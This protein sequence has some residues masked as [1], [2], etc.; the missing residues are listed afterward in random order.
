METE[1]SA[2]ET[3]PQRAAEPFVLVVDDDEDLAD[4]CQYWLDRGRYTVETA[5]GGAEALSQLGDHVDVVLL[6]RRMP[7]VSGDDVLEAIRERD[8]DCRV[9]MMTAV[10]PDTDIVEMPFD[11]YL[12]KPVSE[13]QVTETVEELLVRA[14]FEREVR[15]YFALESTHEALENRAAEE[16]RDP[17]V[18]DEL[19]EQ[20]DAARSEHEAAIELRERQLDRLGKVND[21]L[22]TVDKGL[23]DAHTRDEIEQTVCEAVADAHLGVCIARRTAASG[24]LRCTAAAGVEHE[25]TDID[26]STLTDSLDLHELDDIRVFDPV[27][28]AHRDEVF[29]G[30]AKTVELVALCVPI[31]YQETIYGALFVYDERDHFDEDH[32]AVFTELGET[33][34]NG[35]NAA[36]SKRL[37][38]GDSVVELE[39][40]L[41][42]DSGTLAEVSEYV[43]CS[44]SLDGVAQVGERATCFVTVRGAPIEDIVETAEDHE[45]ITSVRVV[46]E[47][48]EEAVVELRLTEESILVTAMHYGASIEAFE[49]SN[50]TG[51]FVVH[52]APDAD[53]GAIVE[54]LSGPFS[55]ATVVAKREV[56]RRTKSA[57][58][59][60]RDLDD[61]LTS[62]QG[63]VLETAFVSGYF[64]WPRGSTAEEVADA[65][66]ISPP[67]LHE[68]LRTA[69]RKLIETYY[70]DR[71]P[72]V[73]DD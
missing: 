23:V 64:D 50:G 22:R 19:Q 33:I 24:G 40:T 60:R 9:A 56:E 21:L 8:L 16:L 52:V 32:V 10:E 3:P 45:G 66:G 43:G 71:E 68:H 11:A 59:F 53:H 37:L 25:P 4:T 28:D 18:L 65:L 14:G 39:F 26:F 67:T 42:G 30:Q 6:D 38:N 5:Y 46:T 17:G 63:A 69:E 2:R 12:V 55:D 13:S 61:K 41:G 1:R 20:L 73:R 29:N 7:S 31:A 72:A 44:L 35:I 48:D 49:L 34:G 62:R 47:G 58:S 54:G 70:S 51:T 27:P 36:E 15:D 57:E